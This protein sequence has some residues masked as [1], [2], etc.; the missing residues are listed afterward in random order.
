MN[1]E[2]EDFPS[3][4]CD[5]ISTI[6][7]S[8]YV[9]GQGGRGFGMIG[10]CSDFVKGTPVEPPNANVPLGHSTSKLAMLPGDKDA[11]RSLAYDLDKAQP[12]P[13]GSG[14][15][16]ASHEGQGSQN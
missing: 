14:M 16:S 12:T 10:D 5:W 3:Y 7:A 11:R 2:A 1:H 6:P 15:A 13:A 8:P 4:S 9:P